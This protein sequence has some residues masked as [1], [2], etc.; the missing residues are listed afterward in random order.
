MLKL[1]IDCEDNQEAMVYLNA[2]Q[3]LAL[4]TDLTQA[5]RNAEKHGDDQSLLKVIRDFYPDLCRAMDHVEGA[6]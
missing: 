6:Y 4:I 2:P 3:Y 1:N 5:V